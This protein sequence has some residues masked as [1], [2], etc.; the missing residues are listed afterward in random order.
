MKIPYMITE[1]YVEDWGVEHALRELVANG[2]DAERDLGAKFSTEYDATRKR[3]RLV[4]HGATLE[5]DALYLGGTTKTGSLNSI[6]KYGEGLKLAFLVLV[7]SKVKVKLLNGTSETWAPGIGKDNLGKDSFFIEIKGAL[8]QTKN[9]EV[10]VDGVEPETW[11]TVRGWFLALRTY[12]MLTTSSGEVLLDA[13][14]IG[15]IYVRGVYATYQPNALYGYNFKNVDTGR[16]RRI[17]D[18]YALECATRTAWSEISTK[19]NVPLTISQAIY[20]ALDKNKAEAA[21]F[22]YHRMDGVDRMCV[23]AFRSAHGEKAVPVVSTT[24]ATSI[25]H[26]GYHGVVVSRTLANA[27]RSSLPSPATILAEYKQSIAKRYALN[28]LTDSEQK[29]LG[30]Y[31][32]I[33]AQFIPDF[34]DRLVVCDFAGDTVDGLHEGKTVYVARRVLADWGKA[35]VVIL[36]EFAHDDGLDGS[37]MH[38]AKLSALMA[39][40]L[41]A[42]H[43][44]IRALNDKVNE[45][46]F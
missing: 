33:C 38:M 13:D 7:R 44:A 30:D 20:D 14:E 31:R 15:K 37:Y 35:L 29:I 3:L 36:H 4:N 21:A 23:A 17:P 1:K 6:G 41:T 11:K 39:K 32:V 22:E 34:G 8:R 2:L 25:E 45:P 42:Q 40:A 24:E 18:S 16:D 26:L 43:N 9:V 19:E 10:I 5:K 46:L 28:E 27:L 12:D